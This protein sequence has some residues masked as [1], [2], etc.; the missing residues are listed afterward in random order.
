MECHTML[1]LDQ[2]YQE[3]TM[4]YTVSSKMVTKTINT[5]VGGV[6]KKYDNVCLEISMNMTTWQ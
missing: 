6:R 5:Q 4:S 3:N 1:V 2:Y